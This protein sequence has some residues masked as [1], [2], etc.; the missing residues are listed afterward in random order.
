MPQIEIDKDRCKG[1]ELCVKACPQQI[2]A[3]TKIINSKGYFTA[4]VAEPMRCIA[5]RICA[6]TCPDVAITMKVHGTMVH[7]FRY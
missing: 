7:Y 1:C 3:M 2:L 5:C 4:E 6:V